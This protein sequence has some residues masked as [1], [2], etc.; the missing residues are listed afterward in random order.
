MK[1]KV[2]RQAM[3]VFLAVAMIAEPLSVPVFAVEDTLAISE[4]SDALSDN[5]IV[6]D[7]VDGLFGV[8]LEDPQ[9]VSDII[10]DDLLLTE[11]EEGTEPPI[12]ETEKDAEDISVSVSENS[13]VSDNSLS[14]NSVSENSVS[15]NSVSDNSID[16]ISLSEN[17]ISENEISIDEVILEDDAIVSINADGTSDNGSSYDAININGTPGTPEITAVVSKD[18][19][20]ATVTISVPVGYICYTLNGK[21]PGYK[22]GMPLSGTTCER[23]TSCSFKIQGKSEY[24]ILAMNVTPNGKSSKV[25]KKVVVLE[26]NISK[27]AVDG[28]TRVVPGKSVAYTAKATPSY[29]IPKNLVWSLDFPSGSIIQEYVTINSKSGK[30]SVK[31]NSITTSAITLS[32]NPI[33]Y[34]YATAVEEGT[35]IKSGKYTVTLAA[36]AS[37]RSMKFYNKA[38][39]LSRGKSDKTYKKTDEAY[40]GKHS[41]GLI[42][43]SPNDDDPMSDTDIAN[44]IVFSSSDESVATVDKYGNITAK[45]SGKTKITAVSDDR[46]KKTSMEVTVIQEI[47]S[48]PSINSLGNR[49]MIASGKKMQLSASGSPSDAKMNIS[50]GVSPAGYGVTINKKG[51][52]SVSKKAQSGKYSITA[53]DSISKKE[54]KRDITVVTTQVTKINMSADAKNL[55]LSRTGK[56][57]SAT[58]SVFFDNNC[59]EYAVTTNKPGIVNVSAQDIKGKGCKVT[60]KATGYASGTA[61]VTVT[62]TDGSNKSV[63]STISVINED[64]TLELTQ[65][66]NISEMYTGTSVSL[67]GSVYNSNRKKIS[68]KLSW[69]ISPA[70][71]GVTVNGSGKISASKN[72]KGGKYTVYCSINN[73]LQCASYE[74]TVNPRCTQIMVGNDYDPKTNKLTNVYSVG[75]NSSPSS[76]LEFYNGTTKIAYKPVNSQNPVSIKNSKSNV[77]GATISYKNGNYYLTLSGRSKGTTQIT[78]TANDGSKTT[79]KFKVNVE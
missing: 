41:T 14:E 20:T 68:Q 39:T 8:A 70:G 13:T 58:Y 23:K 31:K 77:A 62:A 18:E 44:N 51:L 15:E 66:K 72:A 61:K 32:N 37:V 1:K 16:D 47:T 11:K 73:Q 25:A 55:L 75:L 76:K 43:Y 34:V 48:N 60:V 71:Q 56:N 9:N 54:G 21:N 29:R 30:V 24:T 67:K 17:V 28:P 6:E 5:P 10:V 57:N 53:Y 42:I 49:F 7:D 27:L 64:F 59:S 33:F 35:V 74:M 19:K 79:R 4:G 78:L 52:V 38:I 40:R 65:Q 36:V 3:A 69:G 46:L 50:W 2:V 26:P 12:D 63:T 45:K 22:D